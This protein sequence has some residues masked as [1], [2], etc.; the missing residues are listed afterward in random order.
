MMYECREAITVAQP[1]PV[2]V[3]K[4]KAVRVKGGMSKI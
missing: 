2:F 1:S 3:E 4:R